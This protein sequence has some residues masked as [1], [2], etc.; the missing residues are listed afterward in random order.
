MDG[1]N[2]TLPHSIA[3]VVQVDRVS[4]KKI[5]VSFNTGVTVIWSGRRLKIKN[6]YFLPTHGLYKFHFVNALFFSVWNVFFCACVYI[7]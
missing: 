3:Q 1:A 4:P 6:S 7:N 5:E 2:V